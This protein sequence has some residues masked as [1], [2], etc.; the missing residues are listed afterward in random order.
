LIS[1]CSNS[2]SAAWIITSYGIYIKK[3]K[4]SEGGRKRERGRMRGRGREMKRKRERE[5]KKE[6]GEKK[7]NKPR[8]WR[9]SF[10]RF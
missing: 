1:C 4:G 2:S 9:Q 6:R 5:R 3:N 8:E 10:L 7:N